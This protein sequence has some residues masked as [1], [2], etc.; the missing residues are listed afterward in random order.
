M[1]K[2]KQVK[3]KCYKDDG[4]NNL[5]NINSLHSELTLF[6]S[7]FHGVLTKHLQEYLDLFFSKYQN[8]SNK[9]KIS[10]KIQ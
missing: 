8:Y 2:E 5:T 10:K 1:Y 4:G 7:Q 9:Q 6:L 3:S